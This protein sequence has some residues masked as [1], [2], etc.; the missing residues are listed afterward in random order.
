LPR[1]LVETFGRGEQAPVPLL[2]GFNSGEI[3]SLAFLAPPPP[4]TASEYEAIIRSRYLDLADEFL[5]LYPSAE[6]QESV[7]ATT[8]DALYGW[9]AERLVRNQTALGQPSFLYY[10]DHGYP[11][12]DAAGLHAF[13]ASELPYVFGTLNRTPKLWPKIPKSPQETRL[14]D[15]MLG[16]WSSFARSGQPRATNEADW[17]A[18]GAAGGYLAFGDTPQAS[19]HLLQGMYELHDEA[20]CRRRANGSLPWN[21][22]VGVISPLLSSNDTQC[23]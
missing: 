20:V 12:A 11:N 21:W 1:Q 19:Q 23:P 10:F 7:F 3:R 8:R 22:N 2:A 6:L 18:Y 4:A 13:H 16:Y 17:P 15:A 9:T 5:R 14:S